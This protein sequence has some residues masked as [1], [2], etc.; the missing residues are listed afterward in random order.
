MNHEQEIKFSLDP[1]GLQHF[2][3][4]CQD[5]QETLRIRLSQSQ[6]LQFLVNNA[7]INKR[8]GQNDSKEDNQCPQT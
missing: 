2:Q 5:L 3:R 6:V 4:V 7:R 1:K 8:K